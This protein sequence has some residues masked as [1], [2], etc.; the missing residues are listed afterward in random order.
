MVRRATKVV[1][2][3]AIP[4]A[5]AA[6]MKARVVRAHGGPEVPEMAELPIPH[7]LPRRRDTSFEHTGKVTRERSLLARREEFGKMVPVPAPGMA[8]SRRRGR[9]DLAVDEGAPGSG[10]AFLHHEERSAR[11]PGALSA[12]PGP[13]AGLEGSV[14]GRDR[15]HRPAGGRPPRGR[16]ERCVEDRHPASAAVLR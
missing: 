15:A 3:N 12:L 2:G 16:L 10:L 9:G 7:V 6:H 14:P 4:S 8:G 11:P 13:D 1:A 5:G